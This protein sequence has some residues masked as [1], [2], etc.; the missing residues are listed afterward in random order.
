MPNKFLK[1]K[2]EN[3]LNNKNIFIDY[4][5]QSLISCVSLRILTQFTLLGETRSDLP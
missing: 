1:I 4:P 2:I 5:N 3:L